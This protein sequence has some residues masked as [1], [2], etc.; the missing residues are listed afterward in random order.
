VSKHAA[1]QTPLDRGGTT[2]RYLLA[3]GISAGVWAQAIVGQWNSPFKLLL[4]LDIVAGIAAYALVRFKGENQLRITLALN[5]LAAFSGIASGPTTWANVSFASRRKP[6]EIAVLAA[7]YLTSAAFFW[8]IQ[9][10]SYKDPLWL[11][12]ALN[13]V[14][15]SVQVGWGV[16]LGEQRELVEQLRRRAEQAETKREDALEVAKSNERQVI[17]R[18][19]HDVLA[20][21]I[22]QLS[23]QAGAMAYRTDL[24]AEQLRSGVGLIQAQANEALSDLRQ[25]LGVLRNTETG[26]PIN[27]PQPTYADLT[28]LFSDADKSG[29]PV[30]LVNNLMDA[31][32]MSPSTGRTLYRILQEAITNARKHALGSAL[33]VELAGSPGEGVIFIVRN[34]VTNSRPYA[35]GSRLGLVGLVERAQL[36]GGRLSH[37]V[38]GDVFEL[39]G[40]LPWQA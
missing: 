33:Y 23:M 9:P 13:I 21:R 27:R 2:W 35:P 5:G 24:D 1:T 22:T 25:V 19:M 3:A 36:L 4:L 11:A 40:W 28:S 26:D 14:F 38:R 6:Q 20:H 18:E 31:E 37:G 12:M 8:W 34:P 10:L 7:V 15:L 29:M 16:L 30:R 39:R 17:A 32:T